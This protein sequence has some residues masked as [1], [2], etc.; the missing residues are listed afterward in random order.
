MSELARAALGYAR[1]GW[2]VFPLHGIVNRACTCG[3]RNCSSP[4]KHPLVRRGLH[5]ATTDG[6]AITAWWRKW[7]RANVG[8]ATGADSGIAVVDIDLPRA[9]LSLDRLIEPGLPH[10]LVGLTGGGGIH[11]VYA[12]LDASLGNSAGRLP[13]VPEELPGVDLRANGGYV[14]GPPSVHVSGTRYEWLEEES[15][16][17]DLPTWLE[18]PEQPGPEVKP[19][20]PAVVTG[21]GTAYGL[22]VLNE[23]I[24]QL[25]ASRVGRRNDQLNRSAFALAQLVGGGELLESAARSALF[26]AALTVGLNEPEVR[27][28]LDSAFRAGL[29]RP[30]YAPHRR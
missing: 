21:D 5:E 24:D 1:R 30:R 2:L 17:A 11:L 28:T 29:R 23:E 12:S 4:G 20:A 19:A 18:Q 16:V 9:L 15:P 25:R 7:K 10:T 22:A 3:R 14:V 6:H 26:A 8:I 13:G 27:Q